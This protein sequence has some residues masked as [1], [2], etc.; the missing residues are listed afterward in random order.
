MKEV[1]SW[2][3][4]SIIT[5]SLLKAS[6]VVSALIGGYEKHRKSSD[7]NTIE[8]PIPLAMYERCSIDVKIRPRAV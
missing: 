3:T 4:V 1:E 5:K 8:A 7:E 6:V 2:G